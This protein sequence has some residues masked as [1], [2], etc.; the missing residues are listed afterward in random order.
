MI[1]IARTALWLS[2]IGS[3][4]FFGL[5]LYKPQ[6][7]EVFSLLSGLGL[8]Q[9]GDVA[10]KLPDWWQ[11]A[12]GILTGAG[13]VIARHHYSIDRGLNGTWYWVAKTEKNEQVLR[14][15]WGKITIQNIHKKKKG[16]AANVISGVTNGTIPRGNTVGTEFY[17]SDILVGEQVE[18][19]LYYEWTDEVGGRTGISRLSY[20]RVPKPGFWN[21][22][23]KQTK[24][25][26]HGKF[27]PDNGDATGDIE[28]FDDET[29]ANAKYEQLRHKI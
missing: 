13:A 10:K 16:S 6:Y 27:M 11:A 22:V 9:L 24:L 8:S 23:F 17:A 25:D 21:G 18:T 1:T 15:E 28:Y 4:I 14:A 2:C 29:V 19:K 5:Y 7:P 3:L 12:S 20:K 26:L